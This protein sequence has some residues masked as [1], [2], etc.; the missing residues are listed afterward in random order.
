MNDEPVRPDTIND[1]AGAD[2][3]FANANAITFD[4]AQPN[5]DTVAVRGDTIIFV[6][7]EADSVALRTP[8]TRVID[9]QQQTLLPGLIDSHFHLFAGSSITSGA[10]LRG[11]KSLERVRDT[12]REHAAAHPEDTWVTGYATG[13]SLPTPDEP[14]TRHHLDTIID[15]RPLALVAH[16]I[17]AVW[18]N[19]LALEKTGL[20]RGSNDPDLNADMT[21]LADGTASGEIVEGGVFV[22]AMQHLA[23]DDTFMTR[24]IKGTLAQLAS[25]G[26]TSVH[27]MLG[28]ERQGRVYGQLEQS[29][30]LSAR[31]YLPYHVTPKTPL[32]ALQNEALPLRD[33]YTSARLRGGAV[34]FF[35]DG[36]YDGKTALTLRGYPDEPANLGVSIFARE[37]YLTLVTEA[38]RLGLQ[39]ATHAVGDGAVRLALDAYEH[40]QNQNGVRDSR[41]RVEHIEVIDPADIPRFAKLGVI[42]SMQPLHAPSSLAD[43]D[44]WF[45]HVHADQWGHAFAVRHLRA[46][47]AHVVLGS[48][49]AVVTM[50]PYVTWQAALTRQAWGDEGEGHF[51]QTLQEVIAG[52]TC[53]AAYAEFQEDRKGRLKAGMLADITLLS[54]NILHTPVT[55]LDTLGAELTMVGGEIVYAA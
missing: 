2:V 35:A 20:L 53:D 18:L 17:H 40:A 41:H 25:L 6:G 11:M 22:I 37:Q 4:P 32:E 49:W 15:N 9:C 26:I 10:D 27:N 12:I 3:I 33:T 21:F 16:D 46:A 13:Y 31:V 14:L 5:A 51:K 47:G 30:D 50:N 39:V 19:T 23:S 36:V 42:A 8:N 45:R 54:S 44:M 24:A 48:D 38:D 43:A 34:K 52:Y 29:G 28:D 55:Q 1:I 7:K